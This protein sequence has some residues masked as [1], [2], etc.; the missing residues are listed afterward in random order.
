VLRRLDVAGLDWKIT[1]E[2]RATD[3][4]Q[5]AFLDAIP[6]RLVRRLAIG[7]ECGYDEGLARVG[8]GLT[9]GRLTQCLEALDRAGL[10]DLAW[11]SFIVGFPW[12][13]ETDCLKTV[14]FAAQ[15][16]MNYGARVNLN[17]LFLYPSRLWGER[18]RY[19]IALSEDMFDDPTHM[20]NPGCFQ[21]SHPNITSAMRERIDQTIAAYNAGGCLLQSP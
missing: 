15:M 10:L 8:K 3:L 4:L 13:T 9:V 16:V 20:W 21:A 17:W 18:E 19:G 14:H 1:V 12:E 11:F 5:P 7:V 2:A 6:H